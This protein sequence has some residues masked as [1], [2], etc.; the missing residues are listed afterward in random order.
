MIA[1]LHEIRA[2]LLSRFVRFRSECTGERADN[3]VHDAA[4]ASCC[5]WRGGGD[6]E[7]TEG[8]RVAEGQ[9]ALADSLDDAKGDAFAEAALDE[10]ARV[11]EGADNQPDGGIA[12]AA[13]CI[14]DFKQ[15]AQGRESDGD[16]GDSTDWQW[17][18]DE[19][20]NRGDEDSRQ[21]PGHDRDACGDRHKPDDC[22]NRDGDQGI[23]LLLIHTNHSF[24]CQCKQKCEKSQWK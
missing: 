12:V 15:T 22:A 13:Q 4:A 18:Q 6:D 24:F 19:A 14:A 10:A 17:L 16:K 2:N 3:R 20:D 9:G 8:N 5:R 23:A 7:F 11:E 21:V 1:D